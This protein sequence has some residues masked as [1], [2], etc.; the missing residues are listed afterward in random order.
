M[1]HST[2]RRGTSYLAETAYI[3]KVAARS[4][5]WAPEMSE[6]ADALR[7]VGLPTDLA[8]ASA[9]V[10]KRWDEFRDAFLTTHDALEYVHDTRDGPPT[11]AKGRT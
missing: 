10:M 1:S 2:S 3:P 11:C 9:A 5:R 7:A 4:W 8:E 6:V